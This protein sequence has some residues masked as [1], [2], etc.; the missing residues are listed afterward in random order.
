MRDRELTRSLL[1]LADGVGSRDFDELIAVPIGDESGSPARPIQGVVVGTLVG[2]AD[3]GAT[4]LV[5]FPGQP[6][7]API[8][9]RTTVDLHAP[10]IGGDAVLT[11]EG[12]D[13]SRP[14][15]TGCIRQTGA[16]S[17]PELP[18]RVEID[19][20]GERLVVSAVHG[21]VLR[22]GKASITLSPD[23]KIVVRG[24]H[25]VSHSSGLNRIK[26]G[27]VQVN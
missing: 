15:I 17:V 13:P 14:I 23:G 5:T 2:F 3:N 19:A 24:T 22:C 25:V 10:H 7:S 8:A 16:R 18:G 4:P 9:A 12:G 6:G 27:S 21:L 26:G 11:F 20:D 1:E